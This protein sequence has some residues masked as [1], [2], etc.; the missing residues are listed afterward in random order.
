MRKVLTQLVA[1]GG[2]GGL[3]GL[4][5]KAWA[6]FHARLAWLMC[7]GMAELAQFSADLGCIGCAETVCGSQ[8]RTCNRGTV[9]A[10]LTCWQRWLA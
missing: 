1:G 10:G 7:A 4:R 6:R 9:W 3:G 8:P 5:K 2:G